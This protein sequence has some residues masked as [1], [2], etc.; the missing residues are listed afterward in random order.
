M[1]GMTGFDAVSNPRVNNNINFILTAKDF[2]VGFMVCQDIF[3][4]YFHCCFL[5]TT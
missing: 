2:S 5:A 1:N 3:K 4:L